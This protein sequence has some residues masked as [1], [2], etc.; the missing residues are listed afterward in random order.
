MKRIT[1]TLT[2]ATMAGAVAFAAVPAAQAQTSSPE[3]VIQETLPQA[4]Q[5][6]DGT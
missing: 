2:A 1:R 5:F 3:E 6:A 4:I